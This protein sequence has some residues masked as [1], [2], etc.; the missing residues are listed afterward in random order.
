[1][2][3]VE[4]MSLASVLERRRTGPRLGNLGLACWVKAPP[5]QRASHHEGQLS[6]SAW[7]NSRLIRRASCRPERYS[8]TNR[9]FN[10]FR[11]WWAI[12]SAKQLF[13]KPLRVVSPDSF[14]A[15]LT[16]SSLSTTV[17]L[18]CSSVI[19]M[20]YKDHTYDG[21]CQDHLLLHFASGSGRSWN[22]TTLGFVPLPPSM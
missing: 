11:L 4:E 6:L 2:V 12:Q 1:M 21:P 22:F 20:S 14:F 7:A 13:S 18:I 17:V 10:S 19:L 16:R 9:A 8:S 15:F 3:T 5:H